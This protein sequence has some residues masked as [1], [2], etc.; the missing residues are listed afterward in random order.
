M[1]STCLISMLVAALC[2]ACGGG[3]GSN[4]V[5]IAVPSPAASAP[6][7]FGLTQRVPVSG[8][9]IPTSNEGGG[10]LKK[11]DAF[12]GMNFSATTFITH[13]GDGSNRLFVLQRGGNV[14]VILR[15][16]GA[17]QAQAFV[18]LTPAVDA[19][20]GEAGLFAMAFDPDFKNNRRVYFSFA[21]IS[22][23][24]RKLRVSRFDVDAANPNAIDPTTE[25]I[26]LDID[27]PAPIHLGGWIGFGPD[28]MLYISHGDGDQTNSAQDTKS[29]FGK[30]L[31]YQVQ[32]DGSAVVP[33]DNPFGNA[34]WASG[35][36]NP[37]RCSF[38]RGNERLW[39]GDVGAGKREEVNL[40]KRG[41]NYGWPLYEGSLPFDNPSNLPATTFERP[42]HEYDHTVGVAIV[43]GYV[44]RGTRFPEWVGR[45][46]YS[47]FLTTAVWGMEVDGAGQFVSNTALTAETGRTYTLGEDEAGEL[48]AGTEDG[49]IYTLVRNDEAAPSEQAMPDTLSATGL[50]TDLAQLTP[51]P[52]LID[53][54]VNAPLWSDG[55]RKR[56][57]IAVP[58][59]QK[60][61]FSPTDA[62]IFPIGTVTVKHFE[63]PKAG[64][65]VTRLETRVM[66]H[67]SGGWAG[68]T[69]RWR[70]DQLD[71]DLLSQGETAQY[72]SVDEATGIARRQSWQFPSRAQCMNCH[73]Q[74]TGRVLGL[75]ALQIN[76]DHT[77]LATGVT[78]NQLRALNNI[79]LFT[80]DIGDPSRFVAMPDPSDTTADLG[81]RAR[82]YLETNCS[83]CHRPG[84]SAPVNIDLRYSVPLQDMKLLDNP[85]TLP[86]QD[87]A[88]LINPG[89]HD[90]SDLWRR[91]SA[92][93][94]NT[95]MP[96]LG[97]SVVDAEAVALLAAW[98][99]SMR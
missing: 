4:S 1:R 61:G 91:L 65:G 17:A 15:T 49:T 82:A 36:R 24:A 52:G 30:I 97:T 29:L 46:L 11:V 6:V 40:V 32:P 95:R 55:A 87:G 63:L 75:N 66:V 48:Y 64:G 84:G 70:E 98:I 60:I 67:R 71:A 51:A 31:R 90:Q 7:A 35:L 94:A 41:G 78:G 33:T 25:R 89:Q 74:A 73:T 69:Y 56:R 26:V 43:G 54:G 83:V 96:P 19:Q 68:Y 18:D 28:G 22:D 44:Y 5:S 34:V 58:G 62:W 8:L 23:G 53:Y 93:D 86:T 47:D 45:Y 13:A 72:D 42:V 16:A 21:T 12:P 3:G 92:Q 20:S 80:Y 57:W 85:A 2:A 88:V 37:W 9:A 81:S 27:H 79:R 39:C 10:P 50:F 99:D 14:S 59:D 38:E 76:G 77:Y